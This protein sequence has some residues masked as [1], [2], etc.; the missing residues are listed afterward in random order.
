[1][2]MSRLPLVLACFG[3]AVSLTLWSVPGLVAAS[4]VGSFFAGAGSGPNLAQRVGLQPDASLKDALVGLMG[5]E[6]EA[7]QVA[8]VAIEN[9]HS[10]DLGARADTAG[11][12]VLEAVRGY[13]IAFEKFTNHP[14][15]RF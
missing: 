2:G 15:P 9:P 1:M 13:I 11:D 12:S 14:L 4:S 8:G 6:A 3:L 7:M 5:A 10:P